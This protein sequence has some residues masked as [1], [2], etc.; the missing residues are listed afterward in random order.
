M[1]KAQHRFSMTGSSQEVHFASCGGPLDLC[2]HRRVGGPGRHQKA[3]ITVCD[4]PADDPATCRSSRS[5][6][7]RF[8]QRSLGPRRGD[9]L[10]WEIGVFR[11]LLSLCHTGPWLEERAHPAWNV[12]VI[13]RE[14][15]AMAIRQRPLRP[16]GWN[17]P[18]RL[19]RRNPFG[20][21]AAVGFRLTT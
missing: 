10:A 21:R 15:R 11:M 17:P 9:D 1:G 18:G 20:S 7:R 4:W 6:I 5:W 13:P 12:V 19:H 16:P 14:L 8:W 3:P 2:L